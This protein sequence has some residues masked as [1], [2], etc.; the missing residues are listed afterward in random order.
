MHKPVLLN[1]VLEYLDP[2]P[3]QSFIDATLDGGGHALAILERVLPEGKVLGIEWDPKMLK[4]FNAKISDS[5][6]KEGVG[7]SLFAVQGSYVDLEKIADDQGIVPKGILFDL[8]LS[9]WHYEESGR[10]FSFQKPDEPLDMRF[11]PNQ[12]QL[13]SSLINTIL[14]QELERILSEYGEEQFSKSITEAIGEMRKKKPIVVV[15]DLLEAI[16]GAVPKWYKHRKIHWATKTFQA[17]RIAVNNELENVA[18]GMEAAIRLL[19]PKGRLAVI[20]FQGLEDKIVREIFKAKAKEKVI[21]WV[22][23]ATIR[24]A[25]DEIKENPRARSAKMKVIQKI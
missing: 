15:G 9:S 10:G 12:G 1:E 13:A 21:S 4:D 22:K 24:P 6:F 11:D 25:W 23:R 5:A 8:G 17:L 7:K 16:E 14:I 3:G 19:P 18:A 2:K 20:S